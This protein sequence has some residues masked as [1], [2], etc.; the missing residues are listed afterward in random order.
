MKR[1]RPPIRHRSPRV[2]RK[3][4]PRVDTARTRLAVDPRPMTYSKKRRGWVPVTR[5]PHGDER[6]PAFVSYAIDRRRRRSVEQVREA[7]RRE[8]DEMTGADE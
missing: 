5:D 2:R 4:S 1:P 8:L 3:D 6:T 7:V